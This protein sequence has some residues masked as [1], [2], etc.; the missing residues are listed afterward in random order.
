MWDILGIEPTEDIRRIKKAYAALAKRYN[1]EEYPEE[2]SRL[3]D[4]YRS[5]CRYAGSRGGKLHRAVP[6]AQGNYDFT[7]SGTVQPYTFDRA[8]II[9]NW[10][11]AEKQARDILSVSDRSYDFSAVDTSGN[12]VGSRK[13]TEEKYLRTITAILADSRDRD[14]TSVWRLFFG[15]DD[16]L[17]IADSPDFRKRAAALFAGEPFGYGAASY[18]AQKFA[19]GAKPLPMEEPYGMWEVYIPRSGKRAAVR[20]PAVKPKR[21]LALIMAVVFALQLFVMLYIMLMRA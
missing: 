12:Y 7:A 1:P 17:Y 21:L 18:I 5:A 13:D 14:D 15:K 20:R 4:A 3:H 2:F 11:G 10:K 8:T 9:I 6:S 19:R 16:F